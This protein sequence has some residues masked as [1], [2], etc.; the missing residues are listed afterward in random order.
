MC[1]MLFNVCDINREVYFLGDLNIDC[2]SSSCP[3]KKKCQTVTSACNLVQVI[4]YPTREVINIT[5]NKSSTC[6]DHIF[7]NAAEI[8]FKAVSKSI[9]CNDHNI[10][11][12][13]GKTKVPNARPNIVYKCCSDSYVDDVKNICWCVLR[14]E[15]E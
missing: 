10:I 8:S 2:L 1:E 7:T 6:I 12:I 14:N 3:L 15:E 5:G 11:A 9:G 13:S 4:S